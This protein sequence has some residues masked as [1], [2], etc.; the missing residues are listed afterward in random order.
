MQAAH[1][2]RRCGLRMTRAGVGGR[3]PT[4]RGPSLTLFARDDH[5]SRMVT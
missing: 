2:V 1:N 3:D 5:P 4:R